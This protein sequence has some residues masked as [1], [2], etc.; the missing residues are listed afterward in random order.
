LARAKVNLALHITGQ[1][2]DGYHLLDSLVVFPAIGDRLMILQ[3]EEP[4]LQ[5]TGPFASD[6]SPTS[7]DN[8]VLQ[9]LRAFRN[10]SGSTARLHALKLEKNLPVASGIGGGSADAAAALRVAQKMTGVTLPSAEL[11][12]IALGLGADVPVCLRQK[13]IRMQ[14]IGEILTPIPCLPEFGIV[15]VNPGVSVPTPAIFKGLKSRTNP[16]LP[17]LPE[18]FDE[19]DSLIGYLARTRNDMQATAIELCPAI[20]DVLSALEGMP[21][22]RLARMSGSGATCF[23]LCQSGDET[24]LAQQLQKSHPAWWVASSKA[25]DN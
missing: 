15:L 18:S 13:S 10:A 12:E 11:E 2:E 1:R 16:P 9:A 22:C 20:A 5:L 23:A 25:T 4:G 3:A 14:G 8:L 17:D 21:E 19:L 24:A 6:L 7:D